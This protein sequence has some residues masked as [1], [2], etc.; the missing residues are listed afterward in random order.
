VTNEYVADE[1]GNIAWK[2]TREKHGDQPAT[3]QILYSEEIVAMLLSLMKSF[4]DK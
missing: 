4:A 1:R 2:I 3:P